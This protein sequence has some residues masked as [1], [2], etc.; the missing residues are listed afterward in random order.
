MPKKKATP[1]KNLARN[2]KAIKKAVTAPS[3]KEKQLA[4]KRSYTLRQLPLKQQTNVRKYLLEL[5]DKADDLEKLKR[6]G[7][8]W[9]FSLFNN[10]SRLYDSLDLAAGDAIKWAESAQRPDHGSQT[11]DDII[12]GIKLFKFKGRG[13]QAQSDLSDEEYETTV[14][15]F[16]RIKQRIRD[17]VKMEKTKAVEEVR[18]VIHPKRKRGESKPSTST[19]LV[20]TFRALQGAQAQL[21]KQ[22]RQI[23]KLLKQLTPKKGKKTSA[24][25]KSGGKA[26]ASGKAG[27]AKQTVS[28]PSGPAKSGKRHKTAGSKAGAK[29]KRKNSQ[30]KK[31]K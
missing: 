9:Y 23:N 11:Q 12:H 6:P 4:S 1:I 27:K 25:T 8:M 2:V 28:K 10:R 19:L 18:A 15:Q 21:Q 30:T 14:S 29:S 17:K 26:K 31:R 7:E 24:K 22:Q 16:D 5:Q 13:V 3:A 20:E